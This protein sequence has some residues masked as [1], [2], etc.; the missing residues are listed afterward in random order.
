[1]HNNL[2]PIKYSASLK[3]CLAKIDDYINDVR[4]WNYEKADVPYIY[5]LGKLNKIHYFGTSHVTSLREPLVN[6]LDEDFHT[7]VTNMHV[8]VVLV[9]DWELESFKS[10]NDACD[11]KGERGLVMFWASKLN[12]PVIPTDFDHTKREHLNIMAKEFNYNDI[13]LFVYLYFVKARK[14]HKFKKQKELGKYIEKKVNATLECAGLPV[15][16]FVHLEKLHQ[17]A[18]GQTIEQRV[19]VSAW[20]DLD[21]NKESNGAN[22]MFK[23]YHMLRDRNFAYQIIAHYKAGKNVYCIYG[24]DHAQFHEPLLRELIE[25]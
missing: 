3:D 8:V 25:L 23:N 10:L 1:M 13:V 24:C 18:F 14:A 12:V 19:D 17:V 7:F 15:T 4:N 9:E 2:F 21:V 22:T 6:L 16:S 11:K 5:E 20:E